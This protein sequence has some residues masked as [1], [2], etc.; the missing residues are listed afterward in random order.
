LKKLVR[1]RNGSITPRLRASAGPKLCRQLIFY[2]TLS[3]GPDAILSD[4]NLNAEIWREKSYALT[5]P[6]LQPDLHWTV[7]HLEKRGIKT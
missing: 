6:D 3:P 1:S 7:P 5:S 4:R 2:R